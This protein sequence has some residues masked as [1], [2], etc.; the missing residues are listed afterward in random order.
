MNHNS[1]HQR[2]QQKYA[3]YGFDKGWRLWYHPQSILE[4]N[5]DVL[6]LGINP[7]GSW[8]N[9][10]HGTYSQERG[11]AYLV[12]H[13]A[14]NS[15]VKEPVPQLFKIAGLDINAA[16]ISNFVPFRSEREAKLK[17]NQHYTAM[18]H[19]CD[20]LW[21]E[22]LKEL[23]PRL[24]ISI[25]A[26]PRDG[27]RRILGKPTDSEEESAVS[28]SKSRC[29]FRIDRY[30][31]GPVKTVVALP[32]P[33]SRIKL[34]SDDLLVPLTRKYLQ[35]GKKALGSAGDARHNKNTKKD[36]RYYASLYKDILEEPDDNS[37]LSQV[38]PV[39]ERTIPMPAD[40]VRGPYR[41]TR[42]ADNE[43]THHAGKGTYRMGRQTPE[44]V[45]T[46]STANVFTPMPNRQTQEDTEQSRKQRVEQR[47]RTD[48][49]N[50]AQDMTQ[51]GSFE[52][53]KQSIKDTC[54]LDRES[55]GVAQTQS[56]AI[57]SG[58]M[59][60]R[61]TKENN[62]SFSEQRQGQ[63]A[64]WWLLVP[65]VLGLGIIGAFYAYNWQQTPTPAPSTEIR[66]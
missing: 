63:K 44:I 26:L 65:I 32:Y 30:E 33:S 45:W 2:V 35:L 16:A 23:N 51:K 34:L 46:Q 17:E 43:P 58:L 27:L 9:P 20:Q 22:L 42:Q 25:G 39:E 29:S 5:P 37:D 13:W 38:R 66:R 57:L 21:K 50:G 28:S 14:G 24:V 11:C 1:L 59:R 64:R 41:F 49:E 55:P 12:E 19:W 3:E 48:T 31:S 40:A 4:R 60:S 8:H 15:Q 62:D 6:F 61:K 10:S 54:R 47:A 36:A 18:L 52:Q 56:P 7:G 53:H